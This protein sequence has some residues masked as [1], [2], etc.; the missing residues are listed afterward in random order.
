MRDEAGGRGRKDPLT[1]L[2]VSTDLH[3]RWQ[4]ARHLAIYYTEPRQLGPFELGLIRS[5]ADLTALAISHKQAFSAL[6]VSNQLKSEFISTAAHE[7]RTP[8]SSIMGYAELLRQAQELGFTQTEKRDQFLDVIVEKSEM[9]SRIICD[10]LDISKIESGYSLSLQ[11]N[12][13]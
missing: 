8:I 2:L 12:R 6:Q 1:V 11:K 7:L 5:A 3:Q 4:G 10:L 9:L 13:Y